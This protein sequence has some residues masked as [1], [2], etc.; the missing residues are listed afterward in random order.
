MNER[1]RFFKV[2]NVARK[3]LVFSII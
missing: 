1:E 3:G 2:K